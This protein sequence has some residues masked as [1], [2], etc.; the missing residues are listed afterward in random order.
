MIKRLDL[1]E[2]G[3]KRLGISSGGDRIEKVKKYLN[4]I[5]LWNPK[6]SL[7]SEKDDLVA[8]HVLDSL[9]AQS[10]LKSYSFSSIADIGSGAGFPGIPLAI[11]MENIQFTLIEKSG[12]RADFL[13]N[14]KYI[15]KLDNVNI[16]NRDAS[17]IKDKFDCI[18]FRALCPLTEEMLKMLGSLTDK[19]T[20]GSGLIAAYKGR[21]E[22][23]VKE[24]EN[25]GKA[26]VSS[27][28]VP[29]NVPFLNEERNLLLI[30]V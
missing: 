17:E 16:V 4:E 10:I 22:N 2:E 7:V 21:K 30:R 26:A 3:I 29:L 19:N 5:E 27:R 23:I 9:A 18:V 24:T 6:Y 14:I 8:R 12:K 25:L 15:L 1:L 28:I 11:W 13:R 20:S